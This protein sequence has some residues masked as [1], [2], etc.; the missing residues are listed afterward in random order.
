MHKLVKNADYTLQE[1]NVGQIPSNMGYSNN[2]GYTM[3]RA[4]YHYLL[5]MQNKFAQQTENGIIIHD[6]AEPMATNIKEYS[7]LI[8][9]T[10]KN[11]YLLEKMLEIYKKDLQNFTSRKKELINNV[12]CY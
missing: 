2:G 7:S 10:E 6:I 3:D 11:I 8:E 4:E 9:T 5:E 1:T 12:V